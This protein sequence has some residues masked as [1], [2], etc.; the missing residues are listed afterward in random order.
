L[1][2]SYPIEPGQEQ[3]CIN[4]GGTVGVTSTGSGGGICF[5]RDI[6]TRAL[7]E[8]ILQLGGTYE[9]ACSFRDRVLSPSPVGKR[10]LQHYYTSLPITFSIVTS[11]P[12]VLLQA[13]KTWR[14]TWLFA[15]AMVS[16]KDGTAAGTDSHLIVY[17]KE[18][19][20][21]FERLASMLRDGT[22]DK[23]YLAMLD[24]VKAE[25]KRYVGHNAEG[26]LAEL[27]HE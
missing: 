5:V 17:T 4:A 11:N 3:D 10:L 13:I 25:V 21:E 12:E 20:E 27:G 8:Q 16:A 22:K 7:G 15:D 26:V 23:A 19:Y 14:V 2:T 18:R 1:G 24:D 6:L 9:L